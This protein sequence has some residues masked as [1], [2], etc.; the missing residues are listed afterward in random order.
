MLLQ[1]FCMF[2]FALMESD[3]KQGYDR[4]HQQVIRAEKFIAA[5]NYT[6]AL[7]VYEQLFCVYD[8]IFVREYQIAAQLAYYAKDREK[9]LSFLREGILAGWEIRSIKKNELLKDLRKGE[10]WNLVEKEYPD[11]RKQYESNLNQNLLDQVKKMYSKDQKKALKAVFRVGSKAKDN[12]SQHKF[13]PH[14]ELQ[15]AEFSAILK[16]HGYPGEKL[17]GNGFMMST[18]L[19]HH[20]SISTMYN[21]K[22]TIYPKL[23]PR[24]DQALLNG[25][26]SPY[27]FAII[28]DWYLAVRYERKVP[29]YGILDKP[30]VSDVSETNKLRKKIYARPYELSQELEYIQQKTKINFYLSA[31]WY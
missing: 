10:E 11:L 29:G 31:R 16:T 23:R 12:Y 20:N 19:S 13:A 14:S 4:Y 17:I 9:A 21:A 1:L 27:E 24:L 26:M 25:Q 15:M 7:L 3:E 30:S 2:S 5:E 6:E 8:F 28:D 22:D 18:I